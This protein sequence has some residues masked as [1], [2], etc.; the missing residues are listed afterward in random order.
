MEQ[1]KTGR[2]AIKMVFKRK[3]KESLHKTCHRSIPCINCVYYVFNCKG[4]G[5]YAR[6]T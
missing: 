2:D 6:A 4:E 3:P 5:Q 1:K